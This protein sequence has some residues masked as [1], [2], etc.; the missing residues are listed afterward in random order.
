MKLLSYSVFSASLAFF[1]AFLPTVGIAQ[2]IPDKTLGTESST[3]LPNQTIKGV[4]S[5]LIEGG[6]QRGRNLFHSF[7]TFN[8]EGG[9]G[10]YFANPSGGENILGRVTGNS[11][12]QILGRLGV[13]GNANLFLLNPNGVV[14]GS[15]ASLDLNGSFFGTTAEKILFPNSIDF[16]AVARTRPMLSSQVP[17]GLGLGSNP[18]SILVKGNGHNLGFN[19]FEP[20]V[21]LP[22]FS[23]LSVFPGQT[24][25][26]IGGK[27]AFDGGVVSAEDGHV[28]LGAVAGGNVYFSLNKPENFRYNTLQLRNINFQNRALADVSGRNGGSIGVTASKASFQTGSGLFVQNYVGEPAGN[29]NVSTK[30]VEILGGLPEPVLYFNQ[31]A[32]VIVLSD[33][34]TI[35]AGFVD[36]TLISIGTPLSQVLETFGLSLE[37]AESL[38][39]FLPSFIFSESIQDGQGAKIEVSADRLSITNGAQLLTRS[40]DSANAG[41]LLLDIKERVEV[42]GI[43]NTPGFAEGGF[44]IFSQIN[45]TTFGSG[46]GGLIQ[47]NTDTLS[48]SES[49]NITSV[50]LG[51]GNSGNVNINADHIQLTE[52]FPPTS[53]GS[54]INTIALGE[55]NAGNITINTVTLSLTEGANISSST[56]SSGNA[57]EININATDVVK[58]TGRD[59]ETKIPSGIASGGLILSPALQN[60]LSLLPST[61]G[62][63]GIITLLAGHIEISDGAVITALNQGEGN[64]GNIELTADSIA[65]RDQGSITASTA[66]GQGGNITL[67]ADSLRLRN[68]SLISATAGGAGDGG[69]IAIDADT[70][71]GS[72]NSDITANAF[73][74]RGGQIEINTE[75][76]FGLFVRDELT[77]FNDITAFSETNPELDGEVLINIDS[78]LQND[79]ETQEVD[80]ASID[81]L[82]ASSCME[83]NRS[84]SS[85][86]R[87]GT[88]ALPPMPDTGLPVWEIPDSSATPQNNWQLGDPI[89]EATNLQPNSEGHLQ[90]VATGNMTASQN[91]VCH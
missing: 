91:N 81:Q 90:I 33:P 82:I 72:G 47:L 42:K 9:K 27:I 31:R 29:I 44:E 85:F 7:K 39:T 49:G 15:N 65:L 50:S 26:L 28:E 48:S 54:T 3:V 62:E 11:A 13:L 6:A 1:T 58:V 46:S 83:R 53:T 69:N 70:I 63:A 36:G 20:T 59:P 30:S 80:V 66:S 76:I 8:I 75:G 52:L 84:Q 89:I 45:S 77:P 19:T 64:A 25:A 12:S 4:E 23:S 5:D 74:G 34:Q 14:F 88:G 10:A 21:R 41:N 73:Q 22:A 51:K 61:T 71:V 17:I 68:D 87:R 2:V 16:S 55:G 78:A 37:N 43:S 18:G 60:Y 79:L 35:R 67:N 86:T 32:D 57:G 40:F 38:T 24:L 56:Y